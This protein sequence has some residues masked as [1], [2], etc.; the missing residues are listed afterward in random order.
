MSSAFTR[1][2]GAKPSMSG[3]HTSSA[4][5]GPLDAGAIDQSASSGS[6]TAQMRSLTRVGDT[7]CES[8]TPVASRAG[9]THSSA[10]GS[11]RS[12]RSTWL[13]TS[14]QTSLPPS[15]LVRSD[16]R[17]VRSNGGSTSGSPRAPFRPGG[18]TLALCKKQRCTALRAPTTMWAFHCTMSPTAST[19]TGPGREC[20]LVT[21]SKLSRL[22]PR[23]NFCGSIRPNNCS[24]VAVYLSRVTVTSCATVDVTSVGSA[25]AT[26][27]TDAFMA[28]S[29]MHIAIPRGGFHSTKLASALTRVLARV[30]TIGA[31]VPSKADR[32]R[33]RPTLSTSTACVTERAKRDDATVIRSCAAADTGTLMSPSVDALISAVAWRLW[34]SRFPTWSS[35][36]EIGV[37]LRLVRPPVPVASVAPRSPKR[38]IKYASLA[39]TDDV[40]KTTHGAVACRKSHRKTRRV[41]KTYAPEYAASNAATA[42][43]TRTPRAGTVTDGIKPVRE[44]TRSWPGMLDGAKRK[45]TRTTGSGG[46]EP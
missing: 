15:Q 11:V 18:P 43:S 39:A 33:C 41:L 22:A 4:R 6:V 16:P 38:P 40:N 8:K 37:V 3:N 32:T 26:S 31:G 20:A 46:G 28:G 1:R 23:P 12:A 34:N 10:A 7:D 42:R 24:R 36:T 30:A 19:G 44:S 35:S 29:G 45:S 21:S 25:V 17:S 5:V 9:M 14:V 27:A 2:R 13:L